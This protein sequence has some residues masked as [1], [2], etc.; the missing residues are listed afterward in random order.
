M[1]TQP[2]R[3][4]RRFSSM[5]AAMSSAEG[6]LGAGFAATVVG[7]KEQTIFAIDQ[8][9][10]ELKQRCRLDERAK[11]WNPVGIH[12]QRGQRDQDAIERSQIRRSLSGSIT[13]QKLMFEQ[14]RFRGDGAYTTWAE[15]LLE[16]DEQVDCQEQISHV[17]NRNI[18]TVPRKTAP[19]RR[20]RSY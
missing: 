12:E 5:I 9:L 3:G 13:D 15:Q 1:R 7:G 4:L 2:N 20:I 10:V 11:F 16:C 19:H 17:A 6:P 18:A 14:K 8:C